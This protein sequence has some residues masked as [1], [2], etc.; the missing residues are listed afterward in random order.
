MPDRK[1][2][3]L[4][5][6][7]ATRLLNDARLLVSHNRY[8]SAFALAV[9]GVEEIGKVLL[10][11]WEAER[12]LA[13]AKERQSLHIRKQTAVASLLLGAL[14]VRMFPNGI[15]WKAIDF[16]AVTKAFNESDEGHLLALI[17]DNDLE[18]RKQGALYQDDDVVTAVEDE[19][20]ELHVWGILKIAND[21]QQA[22]ASHGALVVGRAF[23]ESRIHGQ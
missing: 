6:G 12:P 5:L 10:K 20:A 2:L 15:D 18:R 22:L 11:S 3:S 16:D 19:Y 7:N 4:I 23:Y 14:T 1:Q 17:R 13:K 9:L 8:A 21:A